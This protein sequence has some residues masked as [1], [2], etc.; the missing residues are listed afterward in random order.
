M[1]T[2]TSQLSAI[3]RELNKVESA[4]QVRVAIGAA[5]T[6]LHNAYPLL[7]RVNSDLATRLRN[8]LDIARQDLERWFVSMPASSTGGM[9]YRVTWSQKR[10]LVLKAYTTIAGVE[11]AAYFEPST[12]NLDILAQSLKEAPKVFGKAVGVVAG[13]VGEGVGAVAGELGKGVGSAVGG[14]FAGMGFGGTIAVGLV[15]LVVFGFAKRG[16]LLGAAATQIRKVL[17]T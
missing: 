1:P 2:T 13:G 3:T 11:G 5:L 4:G 14:L 10:A 8:E 16:T 7:S 17:P 12:S 6:S 15:A 9:D